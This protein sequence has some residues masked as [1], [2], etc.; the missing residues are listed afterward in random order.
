MALKEANNKVGSFTIEYRDMDDSSVANQGNWDG[1]V[2]RQNAQK[3]V[4]DADVMVYIGTFNSG[5]A[6]VSIPILNQ[7][8][9]LM[10]SPANTYP[11]LT[12]PG[13]GE[14]NEPDV[15]YPTGTRN[16]CRVVPADDLQGAV[17]AGWAKSLGAKKAYVLDDTELYGKGLA[18]VFAATAKEIGLEVVGREGIDKQAQ[19][20]RTLANKIKAAGADMMYFGGIT[21]NNAGKLFSDVRGAMGADAIMMGA[22]GIFDTDFLKAGGD[23]VENTYVTFGGVPGSELKGKGAEWYKLYKETY[24]IEPESYA[25]YGYEAAK[26]VLAGIEKA[27]TKDRAA[28]RDAIMQTKDFDGVLGTWSF[29]ENGDTTLT[30]MSGSQAKKKDGALAWS[31]VSTLEAPEA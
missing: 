5:A 8:N 27:G 7:A 17:A 26:V 15:Y 29:D 13:K 20:Y 3:A 19:D 16:Y 9:L 11:G 10:I 31:F 24:N 21:G 18:D 4:D 12:K 30:T 6:K 22:D 2:E 1:A 23:A 25:A 14:A 28:I